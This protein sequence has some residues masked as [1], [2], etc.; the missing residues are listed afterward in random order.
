MTIEEE[1]KIEAFAIELADSLH[2]DANDAIGSCGYCKPCIVAYLYGK[3]FGILNHISHILKMLHDEQNLKQ[4]EAHILKLIEI[5][6]DHNLNKAYEKLI[7]SL[8]VEQQIM[9]YATIGR[10]KIEREELSNIF[11]IQDNMSVIDNP[12]ISR[13]YKI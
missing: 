12:E 6:Y 1:K 13:G 4:K 3:F 9:A 10:L 5:F 7:Q 2:L 11:D 8:S